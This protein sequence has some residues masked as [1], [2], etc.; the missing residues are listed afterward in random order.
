MTDESS[1]WEFI[2]ATPKAVPSVAPE[3]PGI[4]RYFKFRRIRCRLELR[5]TT[6]LHQCMT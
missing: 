4:L 5:R 6:H 2:L 3:A 1:D